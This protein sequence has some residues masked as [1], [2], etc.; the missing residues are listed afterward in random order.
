MRVVFIAFLLATLVACGAKPEGAE[1]II[2]QPLPTAAENVHTDMQASVTGNPFVFVR[3]D[4]PAEDAEAFL[5]ALGLDLT[6]TARFEGTA[7][8]NP[9]EF[10][11]E[12][13]DKPYAYG[14]VYGEDFS[15]EAYVNENDGG[16]W[17]VHLLAYQI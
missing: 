7:T 11:T 1:S 12:F 15:A 10:W 2:G 14:F 16:P 13:E 4:A 17:T 6:E 5:D 9:P 8:Y 3:F